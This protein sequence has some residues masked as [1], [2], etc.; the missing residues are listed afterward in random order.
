MCLAASNSLCVVYCSGDDHVLIWRWFL[1]EKLCD[2]VAGG[3]SPLLT[4]L[5]LE[6]GT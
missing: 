6:Q 2:R 5:A 3:L 4:A 1:K